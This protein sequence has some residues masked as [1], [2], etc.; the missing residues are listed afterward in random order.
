MLA[1]PGGRSRTGTS[2]LRTA[3]LVVL[4]LVAAGTAAAASPHSAAPAKATSSTVLSS[5]STTHA[6]ISSSKASSREG[7]RTHSTSTGKSHTRTSK[8][9]TASPTS[10][11][12]VGHCD[13]LPL[14]LPP[15]ELCDY[16]VK[17]C[18]SGGRID[19]L[20]LF[21]CSPAEPTT[22]GSG[23]KW[24]RVTLTESVRR[25]AAM[26]AIVLWMAFLF[27]CLGL[28]ASDFFCP[29]L[30]T[31]AS[32]LGL[33]ES[34]AG[35]TF[36]ALGNGSP[37]VFS[38]F[39][40]MSTG[41][42]ALALGELIGAASFIVSIVAGSMMLI[43]P[44]KVKPYPFL[45]D[46]GFFTAAVTLTV[47]C[48]ID[49]H[50]TRAECS[51]LVGLYIFYAAVVIVGS[52]WEERR[53]K[54]HLRWS[55]S[56]SD[57]YSRIEPDSIGD[58]LP[59]T[60][61]HQTTA[62]DPL[63]AS[64][65]STHNL[66]APQRG[67]DLVLPPASIPL[68]SPE[69]DPN[70][71]P[72]RE[73]D[74]FDVWA[75]DR[76][77][78]AGRSDLHPGL[79]R[80]E[81]ATSSRRES[82]VASPRLESAPRSR[83]V[84]SSSKLRNKVITLPRHSLLGAV[85]FRDVVR[86]LTEQG[87]LTRE[88]GLAEAEAQARALAMSRDPEQ[89]LPH[90]AHSRIHGTSAAVV[91]A[92]HP[93]QDT[94]SGDALPVPSSGRADEASEGS[95]MIRGFSAPA[96]PDLISRAGVKPAAQAPLL[97]DP[98]KEHI[99]GD[100][101]GPIDDTTTARRDSPSAPALT[102][103]VIPSGTADSVQARSRPPSIFV[104]D[105]NGDMRPEWQ[106]A[107][108]EASDYAFIPSMRRALFPSLRHWK[109]KSLLG[110]FLSIGNAPPLFLL[111]LTLPV[112]DDDAE[113]RANAR[114]LDAEQREG[115]LR[116]KGDERPLH[117]R[118]TGL[119]TSDDGATQEEPTS[120]SLLDLTTGQRI[121][122]PGAS[123]L[124]DDVWKAD[125][126]Q[127]SARNAR[128]D[129]EVARTL[130]RRPA[131]ERSPLT[132]GEVSPARKQ[133]Q[134]QSDAWPS[135]EVAAGNHPTYQL[136]G[137]RD[138]DQDSTSSFDS[139]SVPRGGTKT[140]LTASQCLLAPIFCAWTWTDFDFWS[141]LLSIS[142]GALSSAGVILA[143]WR[144]QK[145]GGQW[146]SSSTLAM[147]GLARCF[148][149]FVVSIAWISSIVDEVVAVLQ[150]LGLICGLSEAILGITLFAM[151]NSLADLVADI[152]IARAGYPLMAISACF[153]GPLL[154]LLL[155][156]GLSGTYLLSES[157]AGSAASGG[158]YPGSD[159]VYRLEVSPTLISSSAGLLIILVGTLIAVPLQGYHLGP[160]TGWT[161]IGAYIALM[162]I[163][164]A[165]EIW[166]ERRK[167]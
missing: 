24:S 164:I 40:A 28:V 104:S 67:Q 45:R 12:S 27:S 61:P 79:P 78:S 10:T 68:F 34:T 132:F 118:P 165:V 115:A 107:P 39:S 161:L 93:S 49:G 149:G 70:P 65:E 11:P 126:A 145:Y 150:A 66:A 83:L 123:S 60:E 20:Q 108:D 128:R 77:G 88:T 159:G 5:S 41:S 52:L 14:E 94:S 160:R 143:A 84:R 32:R 148:L 48:L 16:I 130:R 91:N 103:L 155:G 138:D 151:G 72:N 95:G 133:S 57:H 71:M 117:A 158:S 4:L 26:V 50:L 137:S 106:D 139:H 135:G 102:P 2:A 56:R 29:N 21:Y 18:P 90:H 42:G 153:A 89:Y 43:K 25:S 17:E 156:I 92:E 142:L 62:A 31:L 140:F 166:A 157:A 152:T 47:I 124:A 96:N 54:Q 64:T 23:K 87:R 55:Q 58:A 97:E 163:N 127:R 35:V 59:E 114:T 86:S 112:V 100:G 8:A 53:R 33:N 125:E 82:P 129:L 122:T 15:K 37:D 69:Y 9:T 3:G 51:A 6:S 81:S 113:A 101:C 109:S 147:F 22:P 73:A 167:G 36:L 121:P 120:G 154:N 144:A 46:V 63:R 13:S 99:P 110:K 98:W 7:E 1:L 19:Y 111:A 80:S 146:H 76:A 131:E 119:Y 162:T 30:G 85:E 44:F 38:T 116:L 105:E 74:P 75:S 136:D 134:H 141:A